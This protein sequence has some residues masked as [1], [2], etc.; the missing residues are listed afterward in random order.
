MILLVEDEDAHA[1]LILRSLEDMRIANSIYRVKDGKEAL[2]YLFRSGKYADAKKSPR[3]DLI[4]L[5]LK[6][7]KLDGHEVLRL[8]KESDELR[9]IPVI[10][11][12]T[13]ENEADM[14]K[15]YH[16]HANSYL[17]K[18]IDFDEFRKMLKDAGFYWFLWN[19]HP[20][21]GINVQ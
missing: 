13:S 5:D 2:D 19:H 15:A 10:M 6:L 7:P 16:R 21:R 9:I 8:I 14:L 4:L 11:L 1:M 17:V 12:T 3:P 20:W 18:P